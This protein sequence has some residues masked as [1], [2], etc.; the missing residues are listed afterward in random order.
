VSMPEI[1]E[2]PNDLPATRKAARVLTDEEFW[3]HMRGDA[4]R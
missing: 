2:T 4:L 1:T 3:A